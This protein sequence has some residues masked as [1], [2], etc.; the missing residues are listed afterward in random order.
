MATYSKH[1]FV[2]AA[3]NGGDRWEYLEGEIWKIIPADIIHEEP[4]L[5]NTPVL[6]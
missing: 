5:D 4:S 1:T 2:S 3:K 6:V